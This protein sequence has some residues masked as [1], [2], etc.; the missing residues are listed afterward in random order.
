MQQ[1]DYII[2][3]ELELLDKIRV[4]GIALFFLLAGGFFLYYQIN[5][6]SEFFGLLIEFFG[7]YILY[8]FVTETG[9]RHKVTVEGN[10]IN[11]WL[12]EARVKTMDIGEIIL[13]SNRCISGKRGKDVYELILMDINK[14][15]RLKIDNVFFSDENLITLFSFLAQKFD[16]KV[17]INDKFNWLNEVEGNEI[18]VKQINRSTTENI[19]NAIALVLLIFVILCLIIF[20]IVSLFTGYLIFLVPKGGAGHNVVT[21]N[22]ATNPTFFVISGLTSFILGV[23]SLVRVIKNLLNK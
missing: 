23:L 6:I 16:K 15:V 9:R 3:G 14:K 17:T 7:C 19:M 11:Y 5:I 12:D 20:P 1:D 4:F 18:G 10:K 22:Y 2:S 8:K 21:I 13:M